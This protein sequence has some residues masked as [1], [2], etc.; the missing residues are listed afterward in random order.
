M[1]S[2]TEPL[3]LAGT[4]LAFSIVVLG[5][6]NV[7]VGNI[8]QCLPQLTR[9][10]LP[11]AG[12]AAAE[13]AS[14][15]PSP[16]AALPSLPLPPSGTPQPALMLPSPP[17]LDALPATQPSWAGSRDVPSASPPA[18]GSKRHLTQSS[19]EKSNN[20]TN[21]SAPAATKKPRKLPLPA[22]SSGSAAQHASRPAAPAAAALPKPPDD[23]A[24]AD[25]SQMNHGAEP[26]GG[27]P[28]IGAPMCHRLR[29]ASRRKKRAF[30]S[31]TT[32]PSV[33]IYSAFAMSAVLVSSHAQR[34][35]KVVQGGHQHLRSCAQAKLEADRKLAELRRQHVQVKQKADVLQRLLQRNAAALVAAQT[36]AD[37]ATQSAKVLSHKLK[38]R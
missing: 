1:S 15:L 33:P 34:L 28:A 7:L 17:P 16:N 3:F 36:A 8:K 10:V 14:E 12:R 9:S 23:A 29:L 35:R 38:R 2:K 20:D 21:N 27:V 4:Q 19:Q 13:P 24:K 26:R 37:A 5:S 6:G 30:H 32:L 18:R 22:S 25:T 31:N 11:L